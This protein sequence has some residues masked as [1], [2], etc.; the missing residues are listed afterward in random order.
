MKKKI[1][2]LAGVV[3]ALAVAVVIAMRIRDAVVVAQVDQE[4]Q[5]TRV[6]KIQNLGATGSLTILPLFDEAAAR[7]DLEAEHGVSYL[8]KTDHMNI[9][10]DVGMNPV[11]LS[12]NMQALG[13][14][15]RDFDA[16]VISHHHPDHVGGMEAWQT[17]ALRAGDPPLDL[18]G[19]LVYLPTAMSVPGV[20]P[21]VV[22]GPAKLG[23]GV[24]TV[25][26]IPFLDPFPGSALWPHNVEQALAVNVAGRGIVLLTGCGHQTM[27]RLV[28]R[29]QA[30]FDEPVVGLVG[31]LHY[32]GMTR[33]QTQPHIAFLSA[34]QPQL[35]GISPH[36]SSRDA[37]QAFRDAYPNAYQEIAVGHLISFNSE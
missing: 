17:N 30:L 32:E 1:L 11:R 24:A 36:D 2:I 33:A 34:L 3:V 27:E 15:E 29:A 8:I 10:F 7:N 23:E 5:T 31:G 13:V 28:A 9:L 35:I 21:V 19:K 16:V 12:H 6:E 18:R 22:T 14:T 4:W 20:E 25:G 26:T 37:M